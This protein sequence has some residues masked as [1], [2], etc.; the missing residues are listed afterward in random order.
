[1]AKRKIIL[2]LS[3]EISSG[4]TTLSDFLAKEFQFLQCKTKEGLKSMIEKKFAHKIP[5]RAKLQEFGESLD[6]KDG[7]SWVLKYFVELFS[8]DFDE[9]NFYVVDSIR[10]LQQIK[11]FRQAYGYSV[12]HVHLEANADELE[13]RFIKRDESNF[14]SESE[15]RE[16]YEIYKS[17]ATESNVYKL[18][19]DADL[20]INTSQ[21]TAKDV[22]IRVVSFLKL[23][24]PTNSGIVD[25]IIGGQFGSEGKGQIAAFLSPEYDCLVRVGGPNAG[26][27]VYENQEPDTFHMLPSGT[28][29][30]PKAKLIIAP[31]AVLNLPKLLEEINNLGVEDKDRL[32]ID[33]NATII[34]QDDID[35]EQKRKRHISSTGQGVGSA[36]AKNILERLEAK[37]KHKAKNFKR[38]LGRFL[39]KAQDELQLLYRKNKKILLEG[40]QGTLLSIHH[41]MY[42]NVTSRDTS[43]SG[44][45]SEI[46]IS[47]KRVRKIIMVTRTYPIRVWGNSGDFLSK[48]ITR[49]VIAERSGKN[50]QELVRTEKG[51]VSKKDRRIAEFSW[52]LFRLTCE[53]NSPTDIALTFSDYISVKNEQARRY[54]QLTAETRQFIEEIERCSGAKVSLIGTR[55][56]YRAVIDRRNWN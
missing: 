46:G 30:N 4:K 34:S 17:N 28:R 38:E 39:G 43:V 5:T 41:G 12:Y 33:E 3:G 14:R 22:L 18:R 15:A 53:I 11:N 1:M 13:M 20:V 7:G 49:E 36:T 10:I 29:R 54:D 8:K 21:C 2:L 52:E 26:H 42:P 56:N 40:T 44:C 9:N 16:Q 19:E 24:T 31:G 50:L 35:F 27:K 51:S 55:F 6:K 48:E 32:I 23:L 37:A 45:L 25:V 47:P